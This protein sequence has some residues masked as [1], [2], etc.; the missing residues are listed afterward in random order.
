M[1]NMFDVNIRWDQQGPMSFSWSMR[2][3]QGGWQQG[4]A[5]QFGWDVHNPLIAK[6]GLPAR[7]K[8][9]CRPPASFAGIDQ[10]NVVCST[11]KPAEANGA[12]FIARF[13]ETR[14]RDHRHRLAALPRQDYR[15]QRDGSRRG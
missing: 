15:R 3:H 11:I 1:D 10:P 9:G 5:D 7:S 2:S 13:N 8:A 12:G 14:A 4:K 6:A